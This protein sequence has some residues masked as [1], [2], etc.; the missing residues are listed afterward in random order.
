LALGQ[1][2]FQA[3]IESGIDAAARDFDNAFS[4]FLGLGGDVGQRVAAIQFNIGLG[5]RSGQHQAGVVDVKRGC[6]AERLRR[7]DGVGLLSPEVEIPVE[8]GAGLGH[9]EVVA[10][11]RR[12]NQVILG[13]AL[14]Q[15]AGV[16]FGARQSRRMCDLGL[17]QGGA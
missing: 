17:C 12:R 14:T 15:G 4:L 7:P 11:E 3:R 1:A 5:H 2:Q 16:Q 6:L 10:R 13:R 8:R 9:P